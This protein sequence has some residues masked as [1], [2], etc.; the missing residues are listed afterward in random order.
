MTTLV[1]ALP[2]KQFV[3][4]HNVSE[5]RIGAILMN[6]MMSFK[7]MFQSLL[8]NNLED[9]CCSRRPLFSRAFDLYKQMQQRQGSSNNNSNTLACWPSIETYSMLLAVVLRRIGKPTVSYVYLHSVRL[10]VRQMKSSGM[11][12]DTIALN[13]IITAYARCLEMEEVIQVF[14]EMGLYRCEPNEYSYGYIVQGLCQKG[15]LEKAMNY[16]KEMRSKALVPTTTIYMAII[17]SLS[18]ERRLEAAV[19]VVYDMLENYKAPN[20]LTNQTLL[21]EMCREGRLEVAYNLLEELR[22][23]KGAMKGRMQS[24]LLASLHWV[25]QPRH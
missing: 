2:N 1:L 6:Y 14:R 5:D 15:W 23:R 9:K 24:D 16:F 19:E 17:C 18:L 13:L 12:P 8:L 3:I 21:E 7:K 20:I 11:I 4:E 25:C 10:L 22:Q